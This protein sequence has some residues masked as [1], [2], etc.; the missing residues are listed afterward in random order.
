MDG[1]PPPP[2]PP[3]SS[4]QLGTQSRRRVGDEVDGNR[5]ERREVS[6]PTELRFSVVH[7]ETSQVCISACRLLASKWPKTEDT[8]MRQ[9]QCSCDELPTNVVLVDAQNNVV[10]HAQLCRVVEDAEGVLIESVLVAERL[11]GMGLGRRLMQHCLQL[12]QEKGFKCAYLSTRDKRDFYAALGFIEGKPVTPVSDMSE[13]M[14]Q[15]EMSNLKKA[16]GGDGAA[17]AGQYLW[18]KKALE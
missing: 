5:Y 1:P 8:R 7:K 9:L 15:E 4:A 2:P 3:A 18:M 17:V 10:G 14:G 11:R 16:L 6:A 12:C 13:R